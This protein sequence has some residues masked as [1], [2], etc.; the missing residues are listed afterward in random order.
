MEETCWPG[1]NYACGESSRCPYKDGDCW[2]RCLVG[3]T[4]SSVIG[5]YDHVLRRIRAKVIDALVVYPAPGVVVV[6][7]LPGGQ[8]YSV[9][10]SQIRLV[11][12]ADGQAQ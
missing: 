7:K 3:R 11:P 1:C 5:S 2:P 9:L 4:T 10:P 12:V 8:R 6:L